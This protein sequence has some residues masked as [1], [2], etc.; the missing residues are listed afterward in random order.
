M[1]K[2]LLPTM[3][4][5]LVFGTAA[6]AADFSDMDGHWAA[7]YVDR[8]VEAGTVNGNDDGTFAPENSVTRA[9]FVKMIGTV[10]DADAEYADVDTSHWGYD[11]IT[12]SGVEPD[13]DGNFRPDEAITRGD[14][15]DI[16][17]NRAGNP[18]GVD[19][20]LTVKESGNAAAWAWAA[21]IM[22]GDGN[23][24]LRLEDTITRA[25]VSKVICAAMDAPAAGETKTHGIELITLDS[26]SV[27][28]S[29]AL[30]VDTEKEGYSYVIYGISDAVY[31]TPY[32]HGEREITTDAKA[33]L[34]D[35]S[36]FP[37]SFDDLF[38]MAAKNFMTTISEKGGIDLAVTYYP[39]M[40]KKTANSYVYRVKCEVTNDIERPIT[41]IFDTDADAVITQG[42][43][44]WADIE[45][46][47]AF[48]MGVGASVDIELAFVE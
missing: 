33:M 13:E 7:E 32:W 45:T 38:T 18:T 25:E 36:Q 43:V 47:Y 30:T 4:A 23:G 34:E 11:Y 44:F 16:L 6:Y 10:E 29:S 22:R 31:D 40:V 28:K 39:S 5:V 41:D 12:A 20:P 27:K 24:D 17:F 42:T 15:I 3:C 48:G 37:D 1:K 35:G 19:A 26:D 21:N 8:L 9:E 2:L 14:V 46:D